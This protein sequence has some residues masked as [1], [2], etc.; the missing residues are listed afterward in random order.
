MCCKDIELCPSFSLDKALPTCAWADRTICLPRLN[1]HWKN[2]LEK[3]IQSKDS[4]YCLQDMQKYQPA[5][6]DHIPHSKSEITCG[7]YRGME[8]LKAEWNMDFV[9][10]SSPISKV[11]SEYTVP[12][13][14]KSICYQQPTAQDPVAW[15]A[16]LLSQ[17][18]VWIISL[19]L[20]SHIYQLV[21]LMVVRSLSQTQ[22]TGKTSAV[23]Q[24]TSQAP[25]CTD[26]HR[27][28]GLWVS[29]VGMLFKSAPQYWAS[30]DRA[31]HVTKLT[32]R[33]EKAS[34]SQGEDR[35]R[36]GYCL[37]F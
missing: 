24:K 36:V 17:W 22:G 7:T 8:E 34:L 27:I 26:S 9:D 29:P 1:K 37:I 12:L 33:E 20:I 19:W 28:L 15:Q 35:S 13:Q 14:F 30:V 18:T 2:I 11:P 10:V 3:V 6:K 5:M 23:T 32:L 16:V 25:L 4:L 31:G 21:K